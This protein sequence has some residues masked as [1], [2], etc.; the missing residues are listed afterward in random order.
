MK[1][2]HVGST[3]L[4]IQELL[5][6]ESILICKNN[7]SLLFHLDPSHYFSCFFPAKKIKENVKRSFPFG[8]LVE[9]KPRCE[10]ITLHA[11]K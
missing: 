7:E 11:G 10:H 9:K 2:K 4:S 3:E 1:F 6:V 8:F 5:S